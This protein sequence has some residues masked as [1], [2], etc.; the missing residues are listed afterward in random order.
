MKQYGIKI[1][2]KYEMIFQKNLQLIAVSTG[3]FTNDFYMNLI[4]P[5]LFAF[6]G[7]LGLTLTQYQ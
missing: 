1:D 5:V 2:R 6:S 4:P 7:S 3:H